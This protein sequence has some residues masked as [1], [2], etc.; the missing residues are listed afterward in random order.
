M[1]V[2][3]TLPQ[4]GALGGPAH[5]LTATRRAEALGYDS[6][7]VNDR[8]LWPTAP[9]APFPAGDG[10]LSPMWRRNLDALDTLTYAAAHSKNLRL[11]TAVLILPIYDPVLLARR[12][13]TIDI[14]SN[15]RLVAG[16]GLGWSPDEYQVTGTPWVSRAKRMEDSLD[17]LDKI[18]AGGTVAHE[19]EF[20]SLPESVF[21]A[22]P[23]QRPRP[24]VYLAAYSPAGLAR[25]AA[26]ADGWTPAG[27]PIPAMAAMYGGIR[28][29][30][31][32]AGRDPSE[33]GLIVRAN[34]N[35]VGELPDGPDR[36]PFSGSVAQIIDDARRCAEIGAD[37]VFIEVQ[38]SPGVESFDAYLEY[39]EQFA[40]LTTLSVC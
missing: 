19:S 6:V 11:G 1:K 4:V 29:M 39:M 9:Q 10:A 14:L 38:Y 25:I 8:V 3:F 30:A 32:S 16:F 24:P 15:G 2:G 37:E 35:I 23:A 28:A 36:Q 21:E 17:V 5:I 7:W 27:I 26:R 34:C 20:I 40:E 22:V 13:T 33:I 31:D 12:L 18:W